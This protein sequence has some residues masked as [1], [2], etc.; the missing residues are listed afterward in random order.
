M[1]YVLPITVYVADTAVCLL[2]G[3]RLAKTISISYTLASREQ[4]LFD[5]CL[6]LCVQS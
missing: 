6:L 1:Q 3:K 2:A 5:K 4:C